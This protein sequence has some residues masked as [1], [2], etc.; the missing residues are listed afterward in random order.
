MSSDDGGV[1]VL[2]D[3]DGDVDVVG[4]DDDAG[5]LIEREDGASSLTLA[6][7]NE[8]TTTCLSR[9]ARARS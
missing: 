7:C 9:V 1:I 4:W 3:V 2:T 5:V 6:A 8:R